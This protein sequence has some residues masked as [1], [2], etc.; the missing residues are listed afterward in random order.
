MDFRNVGFYVPTFRDEDGNVLDNNSELKNIY[1]GHMQFL[2]DKYGCFVDQGLPIEDCR[3]VL[4]Y[5]YYSNIIMGADAN[6][7]INMVG[8]MLYGEMSKISEVKE[9]GLLLE[10]M[11][12]E[13]APYLVRVLEGEKDKDYYNDH[14][15]FL[16]NLMS[17]EKLKVLLLDKV[18]M[19]DYT[20]DADRK[21]A[22]SSLMARYQINYDEAKTIIR[23]NSE[24]I[25]SIIEGVTKNKNT[26]E[27]EQVIFS[28]QIPI[29]LAVLTHLTRHRM[30]SLLIPNF[31]RF[32]LD[33]YIIPKSVADNH[34]EEYNNIFKHNK[35]LRDYFLSIGARKEDL[36]YFLLSGNACNVTTTMNARALMW[37]SRMR[38]CNKAQWEIRD[39]VN[40][41]VRNAS[42]VAPFIGAYLGPTCEV[43]G[44]C[45]EGKDSC[46]SR[47]TQVKLLKRKYNNC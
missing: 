5:S 3:Y 34:L 29:S 20:K 26:R 24:I 6:E 18:I 2:F 10:Q 14:L 4:P 15:S 38:C 19:T 43:L 30:H 17:D 25:K 42:L 1:K 22:I 36:V 27:L 9:F 16:D 12:K 47:D 37:I 44:Y 28:Y 32:D 21:V 41:M 40:E 23:N 11:L 7:L 31:T 33:N 8:S 35:E 45:P 46:R 39:I 13:K